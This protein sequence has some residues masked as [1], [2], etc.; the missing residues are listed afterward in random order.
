MG[1]IR[2]EHNDN[3]TVMS[4]EH[5]RDPRLSLRAMGLMSRMLSDSDSYQHSIAGLAAVCKEG[6]DAVRKTLQELEAAGYLVREQTRQGGSFSA[7]DYMLYEH[8]RR[9]YERGTDCHASAAALARNDSTEADGVSP[10]TEN[11]S[12][13]NPTTGTPST[14]NPTQRNTKREE[15]PKE[16]PPK[17]PQRGAAEGEGERI[18]TAAC[19]LPS[20]D[21]RTRRREP[22]EA[23]DWKPERF[24]KFWQLYPRGEA[25]QAAIR[26][27]D[28]LKADDDLLIVMGRALL[29]QMASREWT[30]GVGIPYAATWLN[31]RRWTDTNKTPASPSV[32]EGRRD[33]AWI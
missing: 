32:Q 33:I 7:C 31:Q 3:Y 1:V 6:R 14:V 23:P 10:L 24:A 25:K 9:P 30:E 12:T 26:A 16:E 20:N 27:W 19:A 17:A 5:L 28:A 21:K 13:V 11:P 18:A 22:K 2:V 4:N 8:S 15:V 29:S